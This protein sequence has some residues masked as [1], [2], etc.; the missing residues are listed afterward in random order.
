ME[1]LPINEIV[2]MAQYH[3]ERTGNYPGERWFM[4]AR[5]YLKKPPDII[6]FTVRGSYNG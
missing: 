2:Q 3:Y 1:V 6:S 4:E 5:K